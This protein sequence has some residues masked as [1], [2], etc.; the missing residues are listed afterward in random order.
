MTRSVTKA[1]PI[2]FI[3]SNSHIKKWTGRKLPYQVIMHAFQMI[4]YKCPEGG[5]NT[6]PR[7]CTPTFVDKTILRNQAHVGLKT[8]YGIPNFLTITLK[9]FTT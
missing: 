1:M 8:T 7:R 6:R 5:H 4:C 9:G 2:Q 3:D